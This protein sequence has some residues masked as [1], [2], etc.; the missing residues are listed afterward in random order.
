MVVG[1]V[2]LS[3]SW[4][5][6]LV[7]LILFVVDGDRLLGKNPEYYGIPAGIYMSF[8]AYMY[9]SWLWETPDKL[10]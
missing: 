7:I 8:V 2:V 9:F 1:L 6:A 5:I 10:R 3:V 4:V